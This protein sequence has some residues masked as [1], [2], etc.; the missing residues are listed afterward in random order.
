MR[1]SLFNRDPVD[2]FLVLV[3]SIK[4]GLIDALGREGHHSSADVAEFAGSDER[5]TRVVLEALV[6][7]GIVESISVGGVD[8]Y[9][10]SDLGR[11]HLL[12]DGPDLER[13]GLLHMANRLRG[14]LDLDEVIRTGRPPERDEAR[15]DVRNF[16]SAMGERSPEIVDEIVERCLMYSGHIRSMIDVGGAVGHVARAFTRCGIRATLFDRENVMPIAAEFLGAS[17]ADIAMVGGDFTQSL[18]TG[19]FDLAYFGNVFH[20]YGPDVCKRLCIEAADVLA[21]GGTIA[22]QD[23]V[24]ARSARAA[25]FAVNMLQATPDG[26]V[27]TEE[28]YRRWLTDAGFEDVEV[29]DLDSTQSQ[30]IL[31]RKA[32]HGAVSR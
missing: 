2:R 26:G 18:P 20:I 24:W 17:S 7:D 21:P 11:A 19:P 16:V 6:G 29:A 23:F 5:A 14:L 3:G 28:E 32:G 12:D 1:E 10:L 27:W 15:R 4:A 8:E 30:L 9:R 31:G 22:I 25:M 13:S